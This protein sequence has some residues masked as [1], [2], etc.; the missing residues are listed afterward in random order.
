MVNRRS[1]CP[2]R[3]EF[4]DPIWTLVEDSESSHIARQKRL[5]LTKTKET[6]MEVMKDERSWSRGY[7]FQ[8]S[9]SQMSVGLNELPVTALSV[10][11]AATCNRV[12]GLKLM[13]MLALASAFWCV[14][15][16]GN[17]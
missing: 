2:I 13:I 9:D 5:A 6:E 11:H 4:D 10:P 8:R 1:P 14:L 12:S 7:Y 3:M 17:K 16:R 15:V